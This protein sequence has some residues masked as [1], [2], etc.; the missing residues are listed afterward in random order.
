MSDEEL[1]KLD[2]AGIWSYA[3]RVRGIGN[4]SPGAVHR[5]REVIRRWER[6]TGRKYKNA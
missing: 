6:L 5:A 4:D 3:W 1:A 2:R